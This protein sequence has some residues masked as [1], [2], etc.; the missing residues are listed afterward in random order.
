M[1]SLGSSFCFTLCSFHVCVWFYI[2]YWISF[3]V[4]KCAREYSGHFKIAPRCKWVRTVCCY[5]LTSQPGCILISHPVFLGLWAGYSCYCRWIN[6]CLQHSY[7]WSSSWFEIAHVWSRAHIVC[8]LHMFLH[9]YVDFL[10]FQWLQKQS[11]KW[12]SCNNCFFGVTDCVNVYMS[13]CEC[14]CVRVCKRVCVGLCIFL[15]TNLSSWEHWGMVFMRK[16]NPDLKLIMVAT[17]VF[18]I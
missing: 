6:K 16:I 1:D 8:V 11:C 12:I 5:G 3:T 2:L 13:A 18:K 17:M 9:V 7:D 15:W 10:Q 4:Q 14:A